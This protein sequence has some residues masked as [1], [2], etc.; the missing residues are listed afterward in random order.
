MHIPSHVLTAL[1]QR[2]SE[3][4]GPF[5]LYDSQAILQSCR[6]FLSVPWQPARVHFATMANAHPEFLRLVREAGLAVFAGSPGHVATARQVGF[7]PRDIVLTASA[8]S[9]STL[10]LARDLGVHVNLDSPGQVRRWRAL[11]PGVPFGVRCNITPPRQAGRRRGPAVFV[12]K[13]SRLGLDAADLRALAG[14]EDVAGLHLY[15][16]TDILDVA[17]F[18]ACYR[19]LGAFVG[20]FPEI[21]YLDLGG[22]FGVSRDGE[23]A[24]DFPAWERLVADFMAEA[25]ARAGR[26]L[27]LVLEP[28]RIVGAEA[29]WFVC[30]VSD[31]KRRAGRQ[32]VGVTAS[33][34]QFPRPLMYPDR[35]V[36]PVALL[37]GGGIA[38]G[39]ETPS[40]VFGCSTYSRDFL[41]HDAPLPEARPGDLVCI[42]Q[43]GAYCASSFTRF[44]GFEPADEY[45]LR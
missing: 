16:G 4:E 17:W 33:S 43:A 42:G 44:L 1:L 37:R 35:C 15:A 40:R 14:S 34:V 19:R 8:M 28:G 39:G 22:G 38:D 2:A 3:Q 30:R 20:L 11:A 26:R 41:V 36:H 25:S 24:F 23:P 13:G 21:R 9:E 27:R 31:V 7:E 29:A 32:L 10:S 45:F 12:G 6:R 5:Y 18:D